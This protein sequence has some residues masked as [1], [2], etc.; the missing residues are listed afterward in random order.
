MKR[1]FQAL[2]AVTLAIA[3]I[4]APAGAAETTRTQVEVRYADLNLETQAGAQVLL[5]RLDH[6]ARQACGVER[7]GRGFAHHRQ[8]ECAARAL[9]KA[10]T[11]V[12]SPMLAQA[13]AEREIAPTIFASR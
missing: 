9:S 2:C 11:A 13:Y 6:A 4:A 7:G 3:A 12:G 1:T 5:R 8:S 10:V